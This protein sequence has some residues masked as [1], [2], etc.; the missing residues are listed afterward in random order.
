MS[1]SSRFVVV[2]SVA[3]IALVSAPPV[4]GDPAPELRPGEV[5]TVAGVEGQW[6]FAGDGGAATQALL[7][8]VA[9]V[10]VA[11]DGT[12]YIADEHNQAVRVVTADGMINSLPEPEDPYRW[13]MPTA[14]ALDGAG[15]LYVATSSAVQRRNPDG[16]F[17]MVAG[18]GDKSFDLDGGG[19][20]GDGG[21]AT[22]VYLSGVSDL[23]IGPDGTLYVAVSYSNRVRRV[24]PD[25]TISTVAGGG[26]GGSVLETPHHVA[27]DPS[28]TVYFTHE[29]FR[30]VQKIAADGSISTVLGQRAEPGFSGDGGPAAEAGF[31][32]V[33]GIGTDADGN[34]YVADT[35]NQVIRVIDPQGAIDTVGPAVPALSDATVGPAGDLYLTGHGTI[36]RLVRGTAEASAGGEG[37]QPGPARWTDQEP[38]NVLPLV[39]AGRERTSGERSG[40]GSGAMAAGPDGTVYYTDDDRVVA[41]RPD[42]RRE[43]YA[44]SGLGYS[45]D[46]GPAVEAK[47]NE[48]KALAVDQDG[49]L[50]IADAWN[51]RIR[52]VDT[53]GTITTLAGKGGDLSVMD[54]GPNGDGGQAT[55]APM[56]PVH[57]A[58]GP[59]GSLYL[60]DEYSHGRI[61]KIDPQGVI[62]S[63]AG[64]GESAA[65]TAESPAEVTFDGRTPS[66]L[67]VDQGGTV[68]FTETGWV[69]RVS[70]GGELSPVIR[71]GT[72]FAGDGGPAAQALLNQARGLAVGPDGTLYIADSLN[73]RV[74]AVRPDGI[75]TTV[76]GNGERQDSGDDGPATDA[77]LHEPAVVATDGAGNLYVTT[78]DTARIRGIDPSGTITTVAELGLVVD[79][80]AATDVVVE[81]PSAVAVDPAGTVF[82]AG[83]GAIT[84][85]SA[86][87]KARLVADL[88]YVN[89]LATGPDGSVYVPHDGRVDRFYPDGAM[90][91]VAGGV[92][93]PGDEPLPDADGKRATSSV[94]EDGDV[95]ISPAGEL[96]LTSG[97]R[98]YRVDRDGR[99][100]SVVDLKDVEGFEDPEDVALAIAVG[101]DGEVY[102]ADTW[103]D[104]VYA[105]SGEGEVRPLAG[106]GEE[107]SIGD[108]GDGAEATDAPVSRPWDLAVAPD[109]TVYLATNNGVRRVST[110]GDIDTVAEP[111]DGKN[112]TAV[113]LDVHGNLYVTMQGLHQVFVVVRPGELAQPFP[114]GVLWWSLAAVAL[115]AA[116]AMGVR[117]RRLALAEAPPAE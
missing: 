52:R 110:D 23:A 70:S 56:M 96:Y 28:G 85:A 48:P 16:T 61:R 67:T 84:A 83:D 2:A 102:V 41:L 94:L 69:Y 114:W 5:V 80:V 71:E 7:G 54:E 18:G 34:L 72:G 76:A 42:G 98:V 15:T 31:D 103:G 35:G 47:L 66:S 59:D 68:Y 100:R 112:P 86:D 30:G 87:D 37:L 8:G 50:Y 22:D 60:V 109:G 36:K 104:R 63:I 27:V 58:A 12:V 51:F 46:G 17:T 77:G 78:D 33:G 91:T 73:N 32:S 49:N 74:R 55:E 29:G 101:R 99:L 111:R 19:D 39:G 45:G 25:G 9:G 57:L 4:S 97:S 90:V 3:L 24:S 21:P 107:A 40:G 20:G 108:R 38:G 117:R 81:S 6:G 75:I 113:A 10:A 115:L 13:S 53:E 89:A 62:T 82:A 1:F 44:G 106:N 105:V 88:E 93:W 92:S 11:A 116:V 95:A 65:E 14:V 43:V 64:G 79:G 26:V